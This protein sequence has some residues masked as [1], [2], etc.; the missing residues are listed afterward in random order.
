MLIMNK[1]TFFLYNSPLAKKAN[2]IE[3]DS[4][5]IKSR[6]RTTATSREYVA[7]WELIGDE[8]F[9]TKINDF[10]N[11]KLEANLQIIFETQNDKRLIKATW[12][13]EEIVAR[14]KYSLY[15][16]SIGLSDAYE[17]EFILKFD[18]G[19]LI[20]TQH[21]SNNWAKKPN[22]ITSILNKYVIKKLPR[23]LRKKIC[24]DKLEYDFYTFITFNINSNINSVE[25]TETEF[26][27]TELQK[28]IEKFD[29]WNFVYKKGK[30][31]NEYAIRLKIN[32]AEIKR[33]K[34]C[35]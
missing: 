16:Y 9:L 21:L 6:I 11:G 25:F 22:D 28:I 30:L 18:D 2:L 15:G 29:D 3:R 23:K 35:W 26:E 5:F 4:N 14:S 8:I 33:N 20:S 10:P 27:T 13:N 34:K 7:S 24:R 1:D 17:E 31:M 19:K 32:E 12:V